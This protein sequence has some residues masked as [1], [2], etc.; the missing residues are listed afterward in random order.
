MN[1]KRIASILAIILA[2]AML[3]AYVLSAGLYM[4]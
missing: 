3:V 2:A 1:R 4:F